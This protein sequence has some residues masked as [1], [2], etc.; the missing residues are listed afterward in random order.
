MDVSIIIPVYNV[1]QYLPKCLDSV[2]NQTI[3]NREIIIINDG[4]TDASSQILKS[5]KK[6]YPELIIIDQKNS[7]ISETRN[8]GLK[9][10]TGEY[11]GFVDSDD[12]IKQS[13]F[14]VMYTRAKTDNSDIVICNYILYNEL[15]GEKEVKEFEQDGYIDKYAILKKFLL[16]DVKAY[17]WNKLCK[18]ELFM[19]N[20]ITF[21]S[22]VVCEDT[23]AGFLLFAKAKKISIIKQ[24]LYYYRQRVAS[25]TNTYSIKAMEDMI[26]GCYIIRD[27]I[28]QHPFLY[29]ELFDYYRAYMIKTL[30]VINN[31]YWLQYNETKSKS[32]YYDFKKAV[33]QEITVLKIHEIVHS[34]NLTTR[35]KINAVLI[36]T[37]TYGPIFSALYKLK[38]VKR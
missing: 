34:R 28:T 25:L 14:E 18:R 17:T 4:S 7:G 29:E 27:Y 30:W 8:V 15:V 5:Y 38:S 16:N 22:L 33:K 11:V 3:K 1:Q 13:M 37:R 24:S 36:K 35:L 31:K 10:A 19:K 12:F 9:R 32:D 26:S 23:P 6:K 20:K 2:I 21:P